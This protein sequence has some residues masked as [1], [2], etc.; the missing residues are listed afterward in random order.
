MFWFR[1]CWMF[2]FPVF[3]LSKLGKETIRW[4]QWSEI[5]F[6][7]ICSSFGQKKI[8]KK[9]YNKSIKEQ[10]KDIA[11]TLK[12]QTEF[13]IEFNVFFSEWCTHSIWL[14][15]LSMFPSCFSSRTIIPLFLPFSYSVFL[16]LL[17][18]LSHL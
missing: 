18:S 8:C 6:K 15:F 12:Q 2:F 17:I 5:R 1:L 3:F 11:A 10:L 9:K 4:S 14:Q 7:I 13:P 16:C